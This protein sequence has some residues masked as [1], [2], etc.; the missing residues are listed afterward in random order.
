[1]KSHRL[2]MM[3]DADARWFPFRVVSYITYI[4]R[5]GQKKDHQPRIVA[6]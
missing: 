6:K 1:M 3:Q 5:D 4:Y 2:E